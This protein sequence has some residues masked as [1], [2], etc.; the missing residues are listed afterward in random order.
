[1]SSS[2]GVSGVRSMAPAHRAV[3]ILRCKVVLVGE[4]CV[5]KTALT[6]VFSSGGAVFPKS[7]L[8]TVGAEFSV[9]Q[10]PIEGSDTIV[11]LFLFD[12]AGHSLFNQVELNTKYV[13]Y[14]TYF[15]TSKPM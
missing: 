8:M 12:C 14:H 11:E 3:S 7:Y 15:C 2:S 9:K 4:A 5:G 6:Q 10:V 13:L 1:M